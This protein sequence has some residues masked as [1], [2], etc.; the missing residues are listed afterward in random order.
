MS[1]STRRRRWGSGLVG[2][3]SAPTKRRRGR[4]GGISNVSASTRRRRWGLGL[5]GGRSAPTKRRRRRPGG[6]TNESAPVRRSDP[7]PGGVGNIEAHMGRSGGRRRS[8]HRS[9]RRDD[10]EGEKTCKD[11]GRGGEVGERW[12]GAAA[13][14]GSCPGRARRPER[15]EFRQTR[16]MPWRPPGLGAARPTLRRRKETVR[17][18]QRARGGRVLPGR[19]RRLLRRRRP[20]RP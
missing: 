19:R 8:E 16:Q 14:S 12:A 3:R 4:P 15:P 18:Q 2:G 17:C 10:S 5:V 1:A 7:T 11:G 9:Q 20:K 13:E 6:V